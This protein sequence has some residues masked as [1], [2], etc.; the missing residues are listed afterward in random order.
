MRGCGCAQNLPLEPGRAGLLS[1]PHR[2]DAR[3]AL[4]RQTEATQR[5]QMDNA[6]NPANARIVL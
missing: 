1:P 2:R 3:D 4:L 5:R 6:E